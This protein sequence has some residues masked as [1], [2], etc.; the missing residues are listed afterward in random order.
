[1][2]TCECIHIHNYITYRL[3]ALSLVE[4]CGLYWWRSPTYIHAHERTYL[5]TSIHTYI[6]TSVR[7]Y[8]HPSIRTHV[9]TYIYT[10]E[11][12]HTHA[13]SYSP[14]HPL[15]PHKYIVLH[16]NIHTRPVKNTLCLGPI[17]VP[18][19]GKPVFFKQR[20]TCLI[21]NA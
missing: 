2:Y 6:H 1:M 19:E 17:A 21:Y 12:T 4:L 10:R 14:T 5:P 15:P 8:I 18:H 3:Y 20:S 9:C 7:T 13:R 11:C 16:I